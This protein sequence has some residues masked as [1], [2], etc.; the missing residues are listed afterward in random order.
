ML[1]QLV[2][3]LL[4]L[5]FESRMPIGRA[6]AIFDFD[7][8]VECLSLSVHRLALQGVLTSSM[9]LLRRA[10][11]KSGCFF[12]H[13]LRSLTREVFTIARERASVG[14]SSLLPSISLEWPV[15]GTECCPLPP[16]VA[17]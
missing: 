8:E 5:S 3:F 12:L 17:R 9:P 16:T 10:S 4:G 11:E 7:H 14:Y 6:I 2:C 13:R 1:D 15:P